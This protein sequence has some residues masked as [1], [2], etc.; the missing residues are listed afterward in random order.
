LKRFCLP[1]PLLVRPPIFF[2]S[3]SPC[4]C[5]VRLDHAPVQAE[6]CRFLVA[7]E[8][9]VLKLCLRFV[10]HGFFFRAYDGDSFDDLFSET[11]PSF[12]LFF[13]TLLRPFRL[14]DWFTSLPSLACT[15]RLIV[16]QA[17]AS[18]RASI[19]SQCFSFRFL[20][21]SILG[22]RVPC[23]VSLDEQGGRSGPVHGPT[24]CPDFY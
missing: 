11:V 23:E 3:R 16:D 10:F 4:L 14:L 9:L 19:E 22:P 17:F 1:T 24:P 21:Y 7:P 8:D 15:S 2:I 13:G 6:R 18:S 20:C 12:P 5:P